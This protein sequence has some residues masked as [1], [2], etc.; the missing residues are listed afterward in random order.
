MPRIPASSRMRRCCGGRRIAASRCL[1]SARLPSNRSLQSLE[2]LALPDSAARPQK[3]AERR[4]VLADWR[5]QVVSANPSCS[6]RSDPRRRHAD[7]R[8]GTQRQLRP[9]CPRYAFSN[10]SEDILELFRAGCEATGVHCTRSSVKQISIY[11]KA[12]VAR[13]DESS[14]RR[15][16]L[17]HDRNALVAASGRAAIPPSRAPSRRPAPRAR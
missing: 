4:I 14:A 1:P 9:A 7:H 3:E 5:Q 10:R 8:Y 11:S 12:A 16:E 13:L 2:A 17:N 6:S 15:P